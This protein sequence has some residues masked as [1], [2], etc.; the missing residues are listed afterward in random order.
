MKRQITKESLELIKHFEGLYL[1]PYLCPAKIP[2]I[3]I[4]TIAYPNGKK[5]SLS[6]P[7]ITE[8]KAFEYL[9]FELT[10][11]ADLVHEFLIKSSV[12]LN[13]QQYS[14]LV[15]FAYNCGAGPILDKGRSMHEAI[16]SD[17]IMEIAD[18]FLIYNKATT[19]RG[20]FKRTVELKGLTRRR[21]A[22]RYLFLNGM[23]NFYGA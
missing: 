23:N 7:P 10:E 21:K 11:K 17:S 19:G 3:G 9:M 6:D 13:D 4:G 12:L 14:A 5:V 18:C 8:E 20:I 15:S 22:E 2:T 1:K 16:L